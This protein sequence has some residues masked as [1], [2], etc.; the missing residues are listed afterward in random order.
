MDV[1]DHNLA[2]RPYLTPWAEI[3]E[4]DSSN[5]LL[6]FEQVLL[7]LR[8]REVVDILLALNGA[9]TIA[10]LSAKHGVQRVQALLRR[11]DQFD[12]ILW[13]RGDETSCI[14]VKSRWTFPV[15]EIVDAFQLGAWRLEEALEAQGCANWPGKCTRL[16]LTDSLTR[17]GL[18]LEIER[19]TKGEEPWLLLKLG[20]TAVWLSPVFQSGL[21]PCWNCLE[22]RLVSQD[23]ALALG[24]S[25]GFKQRYVTAPCEA[26]SE[27]LTR[28]G[29][30]AAAVHIRQSM[31][32]G[33]VDRSRAELVRIDL[34]PGG[35]TRHPVI[36][37]P[38][39]LVCSGSHAPVA[40]H[41]S[42]TVRDARDGGIRSH[43]WERVLAH[44]G[45]LIDPVT[46]IVA[47]VRMHHA[48]P[49]AVVR[50]AIA[51]YAD[52]TSGKLCK[53]T[54]D[55][56]SG[57]V[58]RSRAIS[59][60]AFGGGLVVGEAR[61][62]AVL[63]A[64]ERYCG[65]FQG[66][67]I[68]VVASLNE[69][70]KEAIRPDRLLCGAPQ[71]DRPAGTT[72]HAL[73]IYR[74]KPFDPNVPIRWSQIKT[75][76]GAKR[77][78][79]TAYCYDCYDEQRDGSYFSYTTNGSAVAFSHTEA[80]I[81][82]FLELIERDAVG[83]WWY[84]RIPRPVVQIRTFSDE[85]IE[86]VAVHQSVLGRQLLVFDVTSDLEIPVFAAMSLRS[87]ARPPLFG[88]A[89]HFNADRAL[90]AALME[91]EQAQC[92]QWQEDQKW[93]GF[94]WSTQPHLTRR[95]SGS[96]EAEDYTRYSAE[97]TIENCVAAAAAAGL[98]IFVSDRTRAD[99][100]LPA[101]KV[102]VPGLRDFRP[103]FGPGRL[104]EIPVK[105]GWLGEPTPLGQLNPEYL[106]S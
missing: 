34:G 75:L 9:T 10:A 86:R 81:H 85:F 37:Y 78:A 4:I 73:E 30:Q 65:I 11:L 94:D 77:Y 79:P 84:N 98:E 22:R 40:F 102:I 50:V 23:D 12:L 45:H 14:S 16:L 38:G 44:A 61:A 58:G 103:Q 17:P 62:R 90:A 59:R 91:L 7:Q 101:V 6:R 25:E 88:F 24:R 19:A 41:Q 104:F 74:S 47:E 18:A 60:E 57:R 36:A 3:S 29:A 15:I 32:S 28:E 33:D 54:L 31:I 82:G 105:L 100:G 106:R 63:E 27:L 51:K 72:A 93:T 53:Y 83:I 35:V 49:D 20:A 64:F 26:N 87:D 39:C 92:F 13:W 2:A 70:G 71:E 80:I 55:L 68:T 89:A 8:G 43:L 66:G 95:E 69:L 42:R 97:P 21:A 5:V 48:L 56:S 76:S 99:I 67:E 96:R 1:G 52:P 46:G